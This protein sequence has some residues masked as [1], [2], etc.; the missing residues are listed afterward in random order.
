MVPAGNEGGEVERRGKRESLKDPGMEVYSL[1]NE[2]TVK[3]QETVKVQTAR[4][5]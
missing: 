5:G 3:T 2:K 4:L 1:K